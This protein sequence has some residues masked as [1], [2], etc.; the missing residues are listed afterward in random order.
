MHAVVLAAAVGAARVPA[1]CAPQ[2]VARVHLVDGMPFISAHV[3][4]LRI[5]RM[6]GAHVSFEL[7]D[8]SRGVA[9]MSFEPD[10]SVVLNGNVARGGNGAVDV[11]A[12]PNGCRSTGARIVLSPS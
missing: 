10:G 1:Q 9:S 6:N 3:P 12:L 4:T 5:R 7:F 8:G 2:R 11:E